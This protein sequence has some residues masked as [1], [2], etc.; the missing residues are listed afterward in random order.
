MNVETT[1]TCTG[2]SGKP[3]FWMRFPDI[4]PGGCVSVSNH[5]SYDE[6]IRKRSGM[7]K[8]VLTFEGGELDGFRLSQ[9]EW[10]GEVFK[11]GDLTFMPVLSSF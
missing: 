9:L 1:G 6:E 11:K 2:G 7:Q 5:G 3:E 8:A 4:F 10:A